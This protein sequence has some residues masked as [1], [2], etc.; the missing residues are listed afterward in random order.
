MYVHGGIGSEFDILHGVDT[1]SWE[2]D[3]KLMAGC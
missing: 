2:C 3:C 1:D